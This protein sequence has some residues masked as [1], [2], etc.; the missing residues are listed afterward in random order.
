[1]IARMLSRQVTQTVCDWNYSAINGIILSGS[2][3]ILQRSRI[4]IAIVN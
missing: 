3:S 2:Q 4:E 1:M